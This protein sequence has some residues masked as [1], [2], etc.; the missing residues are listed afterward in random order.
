MTLVKIAGRSGGKGDGL[1]GGRG[2]GWREGGRGDG[3]REGCR[4]STHIGT[5]LSDTSEDSWSEGVDEDLVLH[6]RVQQQS[7]AVLWTQILQHH[8]ERCTTNTRQATWH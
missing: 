6:L 4:A 1:E 5:S 3:G 7:H 2:E 8:R